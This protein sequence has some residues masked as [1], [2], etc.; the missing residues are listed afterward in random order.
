MIVAFFIVEQ[1]MPLEMSLLAADVVHNTRVALDHV[2]ARLKDRFGGDPGRGSFP[3]WQSEDLWRE[4]V[5]KKGKGSALHRLEKPVV[6]LIHEEQPLH[7]TTPEE[8]PL[9]ILNRL[10]NADKHRLL[11]PAFVYPGVKCGLDLIELVDPSKLTSA[12]NLWNAG[13]P[14]EDGTNLALFIIRGEPNRAIRARHDAPIGFASGE[15]GGPRTSYRAMMDRVRGIADRAGAL[16]ATTDG[17]RAPASP[18]NGQHH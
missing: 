4:H 14:L 2:L 8:D 6:D 15:V 5:V 1:P 10:D 17:R 11:H 3:T 9:V 18:G 13:L 12:R 16:I 7:R